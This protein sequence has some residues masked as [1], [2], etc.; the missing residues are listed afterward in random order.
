MCELFAMSSAEPAT[1][2][3]SLHELARHGG[4]TAPH[5]DGWGVAYYENNDVRLIRDTSCASKSPWI[6]FL[7]QQNLRSK[8]V[9]SH[10][11]KATDGAIAI[12]NTQ[13]FARELGG[14]M[15]LF[16]HNGHIPTIKDCDEFVL[17]S[18]KPIGDTDSEF[19]FCVLLE[20]LRSIWDG[21]DETPDAEQRFEIVARFAQEIGKQGLAN[22][23][24]SDGE[25][26]IVH[27]HRR[28]QTDGSFR[29]PG[30][31][32][33]QRECSSR[34]VAPE[35]GAGIRINAPNQTVVL[36]ASV[37]L[38]DEAW[39][40]LGEGDLVAIAAGEIKTWRRPEGST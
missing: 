11:R 16:A 13:P 27:G 2:S 40:P 1:I 39:E 7:E 26:L 15:H 9:M 21:K 10:L 19:A 22:F 38:T 32:L 33:L 18:F 25:L 29:A 17:G 3:F 34:T 36:V 23:L 37:P 20:R 6:Q 8:M 5:K 14:R 30:L 4:G 35:S 31:F 24:Y 28:N 12:H